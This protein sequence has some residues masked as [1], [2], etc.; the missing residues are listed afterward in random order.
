M[1]EESSHVAPQVLRPEDLPKPTIERR[2]RDQLRR[3][4]IRPGREPLNGKIE[5]DPE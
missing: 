2:S 4:M 5:V 1:S 3:A